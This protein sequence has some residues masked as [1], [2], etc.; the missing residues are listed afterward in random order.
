MKSV[1]VTNA[2]RYGAAPR[3][4]RLIR[5]NTLICEVLDGSSTAPHLRRAHTF[6]EGGRGLFIVAN[7]TE[8]WGTRYTG[9]GKAIWAELAG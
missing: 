7:L 1:D 9:N 3:Q 8:R 4:L 5:D 2:I 6:D